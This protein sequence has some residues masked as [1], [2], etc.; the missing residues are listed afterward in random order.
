[1][2]LR[3]LGL[4]FLYREVDI[5]RGETRA[6]WFLRIPLHLSTESDGT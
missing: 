2:T 4:P 3:E 1:L 6:P 5:L